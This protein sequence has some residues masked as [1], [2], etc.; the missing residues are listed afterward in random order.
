MFEGWRV[1]VGAQHRPQEAPRG[2]KKHHRK[3]K[4]ENR[5][6]EEHQG[7]QKEA[8]KALTPFDPATRILQVKGNLSSLVAGGP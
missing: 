2:D 6:Q 8:Q 5:R 1:S 3:K 4:N 7:P